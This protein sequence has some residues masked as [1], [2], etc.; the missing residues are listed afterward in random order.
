MGCKAC[1]IVCPQT[2]VVRRGIENPSDEQK[3]K[4]LSKSHQPIT[5]QP[6]CTAHGQSDSIVPKFRI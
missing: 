5:A 4:I 6:L 3:Q 1:Q 2:V